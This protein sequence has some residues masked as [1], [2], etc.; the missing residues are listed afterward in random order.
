ML[1]TKN[2][3]LG[4]LADING[5]RCATSQTLEFGK[6]TEDPRIFSAME[7]RVPIVYCIAGILKQK[8][9]ISIDAAL[10]VRYSGSGPIASDTILSVLPGGPMTL[11]Q[12]FNIPLCIFS[13]VIFNSM[14]FQ[15]MPVR[16]TILLL[17]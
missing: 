13:V 17:L 11:T 6:S 4:K 3:L 15:N 9:G 5:V 1:A 8:G 16:T 10:G 14:N 2:C 7:V 12:N